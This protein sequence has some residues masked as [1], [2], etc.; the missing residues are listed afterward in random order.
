MSKRLWISVWAAILAT[1]PLAVFAQ[2]RI[3]PN[4]KAPRTPYGQ[5]DLQ[6][7]WSNATVTPLERPSDLG[8]KA[9]F[10]EQEA[11][12]YAK[13]SVARND[14]D[15]RAAVADTDVRRAYND[16][17]WDSGK[18]VVA[19]RRTSLIV[20]PPNGRL[21]PMTPEGKRRVA[22]RANE[23][24][25]EF[26][27]SAQQRPL[28]ERCIHFDSAGPPM[29]PSAYNNNYQ[30]VQT[31]KYVLI[32]NEMAHE[33]RIIPL[34]GRPPLPSTVRQ[35]NGSSRGHW[36]GDT[37]VIETTNFRTETDF[38]GTSENMHLTER[39]T[40]IA[41]DVLLYEFTVD[42]PETYTRP[43]TVQI[44][45]TRTDGLMYE[46]AC[47][48]G[49]IAMRDMLAGARLAERKAAEAAEKKRDKEQ[50]K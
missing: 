16:F 2:D 34:D 38:R 10:T 21:P 32:V 20:D 39:F 5:P 29:M 8:D 24:S 13:R 44:P 22:M 37:L 41:P 36:D 31:D 14:K 28:M 3:D 48:E 11:E 18:H 45:S 6:G 47:N 4:Y 43:W 42:D 1:A 15:Q 46:Y 7:I 50:A 9:F 17:W 49:N 25:V 27:D 35:W 33:T 23:R 40:R 12:A 26:T 30:L 19:T